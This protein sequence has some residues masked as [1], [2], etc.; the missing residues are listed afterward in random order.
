MIYLLFGLL[1]VAVTALPRMRRRHYWLFYRVHSLVL[2]VFVLATLAHSWT[3]WQY[4]LVGLLL[5]ALDK[6]L[7]LRQYLAQLRVAHTV[8][9]VR[10]DALNNG[11]VALTCTPL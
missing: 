6:A 8:H 4:A 5:Y 10:F 7:Q 11:A 1:C 9:L 2:P 3:A